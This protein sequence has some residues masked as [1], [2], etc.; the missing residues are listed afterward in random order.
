M[1]QGQGLRLRGPEDG[2]SWAFHGD[3]PCETTWNQRAVEKERPAG[4][5]PVVR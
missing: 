1:V 3:A 5:L 2:R 4:S